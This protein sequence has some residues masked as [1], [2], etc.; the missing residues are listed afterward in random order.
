MLRRIGVMIS[1]GLA[2]SLN[3]STVGPGLYLATV[4]KPV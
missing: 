1:V 3:P 4:R 2:D